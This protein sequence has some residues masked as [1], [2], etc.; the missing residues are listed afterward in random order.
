[1]VSLGAA[2]FTIASITGF[3]SF[4]GRTDFDP[5]RIV[6]SVVVGIGFIGAGAILR[7]ERKII[8][9]T[10][11]ASLWAV[12]AIGM[13]TG[14]GLLYTA[15]FSTIIVYIVLTLFWQLEEKVLHK[16]EDECPKDEMMDD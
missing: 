13:A 14:L 3:E 16:D 12:A 10:T 2:I 7:K 4:I 15:V 8:G 6:A 1:L 5:S 11:A 9:T